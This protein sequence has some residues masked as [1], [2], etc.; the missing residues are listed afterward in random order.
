MIASIGKRIPT[1]PADNGRFVDYRG[2]TM[3]W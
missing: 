3:P 2:E 1:T